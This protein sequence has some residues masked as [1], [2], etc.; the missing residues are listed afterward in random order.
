VIAKILGYGTLEITSG[1]EEKNNIRFEDAPNPQKIVY[2]LK[3]IK[4]DYHKKGYDK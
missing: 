1:D 3:Q 4:T 2:Q